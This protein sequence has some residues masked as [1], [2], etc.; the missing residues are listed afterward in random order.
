M[1]GRYGTAGLQI[2]GS[3]DP[4][5][6]GYLVVADEASC[7]LGVFRVDVYGDADGLTHGGQHLELDVPDGIDRTCADEF[8]QLGGAGV[9]V[10]CVGR[11][12]EM[13]LGRQLAG[14]LHLVQHP[15]AALVV[16]KKGMAAESGS[17]LYV[18]NRPDYL[19]LAAQAVSHPD[20]FLRVH[21]GAGVCCRSRAYGE[22]E[23]GLCFPG[24]SYHFYDL[25]VCK[26]HDALGLGDA[27]KADAVAVHLGQKRG[28]HFRALDAGHLETVLSTVRKSLVRCG[29]VIGVPS[30]QTY[31]SEE[32]SCLFHKILSLFIY[33]I[34]VSDSLSAHGWT[35]RWTE[36][37]SL[38]RC[39]CVCP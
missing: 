12:L 15:Q 17:A 38:S 28:H 22:D 36:G 23:V 35:C 2:D 24:Q 34:R 26:H 14:L 9:A 8:Q 25:V 6:L 37:H 1:G 29:E 5:H 16:H 31:R 19:L 11:D 32:F 4:D 21:G 10:S 30:R 18:L 7:G 13:G 20:T 3:C 33:S 27:V 39:V